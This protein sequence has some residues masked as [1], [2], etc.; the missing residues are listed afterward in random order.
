MGDP[1]GA[2]GRFQRAIYR[3]H[4]SHWPPYIHTGP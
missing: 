4:P 1:P 2:D 3:V